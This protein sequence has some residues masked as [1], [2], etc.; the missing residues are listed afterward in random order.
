MPVG[1]FF[2]IEGPGGQD[3]AAGSMRAA[4]GS[5]RMGTAVVLCARIGLEKMSSMLSTKPPTAVLL[6]QKRT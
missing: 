5:Y 6:F 4:L 3:T 2:Y 1:C